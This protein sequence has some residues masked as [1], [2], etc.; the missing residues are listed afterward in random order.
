MA[1]AK[2]GGIVHTYQKYDPVNLP[3]P[4]QPPPDL[5]SSAFEHSLMFGNHRKLT[6]EELA[7]AVKIDPS[8]IQGFGPSLETIQAMLEERKRKILATYETDTVQDR[9]A[10]LLVAKGSEQKP[11]KAL[12]ERYRKA[13]FHEQI[14]ELERLW[15]ANDDEHN[16][17]AH[18]LLQVM[19]TMGDKYQVDELASKYDFT[20]RE[21]MTVP[22][23]LEIKEQLEKIDELLEQLAEAM[24]NATIGVIDMEALEEFAESG[25]MDELRN[26]QKQVE[27][28]LKEMAER[29]GLELDGNG[30]FRLTPEAYKIF[31][32]KL[33]SRIFSN[34]Q[35]SRSGRHQGP[36]VGEGAVEMQQTKP[37]EFGDSITQMD[38]SQSI[39][40]SMLRQGTDQ[41]LKFRNEDIEIHKTR[42]S[43]KC[44]TVVV[45]D[46]SGSTRYNG[47]Y[48]NVKRMALALDGLIRSEYP[49]DYLQFVEMASFAKPVPRGEIINLLPKP[50]TISDPVVQLKVDMSRVDVSE[51]MIPPHFTN[52]QHGLQQ[53]RRYLATQDTP[54]RQVIVITDGLPTAHFEESWLYLLYPPHERT[55][56]FTFREAMLCQREGI[57]INIFLVPSWSQTEEDIQF[58][59]KLAETTQGRVIFTAGD[60]LD[61]FVIWDYVSRK[62]EILG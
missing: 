47:Q 23:A 40:N 39:I 59:H 62:K 28:Y 18:H 41:P 57:T 19:Q 21:S 11:P 24:E 36:I 17:F 27:D 33:L 12:A 9:A 54:N 25:Q 44:A 55:E 14:Y 52:I 31:Q 4:T 7:K 56:E 35:A 50:V 37:Y 29:Q 8:Q 30:A 38:I 2:H 42:N 26:M 45:M 15:Y 60:D 5:V 46:V 3:S 61:R 16:P 43:P 13:I 51:P 10:K 34:L 6:P 48:M 22:E 32:G 1:S 58:A 53:A 49:G 20:G